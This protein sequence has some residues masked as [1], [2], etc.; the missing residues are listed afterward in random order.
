[1]AA[2][3]LGGHGDSD[4]RESYTMAEWADEVLALRSS[5]GCSGNPVLIGHSMGGF[6]S[7]VT[8]ALHG[9]RLAA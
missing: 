5:I 8:A 6:V 1:V 3:D 4:H 7:I 9:D 2:L